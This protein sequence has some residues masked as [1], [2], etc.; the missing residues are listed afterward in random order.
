M[1]LSSKTSQKLHEACLTERIHGG[2]EVLEQE[3]GGHDDQHQEERVV[4]E[5]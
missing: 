1:Q 2:V 5:D 4:V 3:E